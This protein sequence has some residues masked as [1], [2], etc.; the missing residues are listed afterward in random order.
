MISTVISDL[1]KVIL[2]FDNHIFFRKLAGYCSFSAQ[3]IAARVH[4]HRDLIR[5]FDTG[6]IGPT[7][8]YGEVMQKLEADIGQEVFFRI[9]CDIFSLNPPVLDLLRRLKTGYRMILLSNTDVERFGFVKKKFPEIFIFDEYVLSYEVGYLKPH[10]RIYKEALAKADV[11]A[12]ECV[13]LDD[14]QE[15]IEGARNVGMNAI[16]CEPHTDLAAELKKMNVIIEEGTR[17]G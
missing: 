1:G 17:C 10:P 3:D 9:Y 15:N 13:F 7:D 11:R 6:R 4:W 14:L 2:F 12:E 8:F 16:L 5:A